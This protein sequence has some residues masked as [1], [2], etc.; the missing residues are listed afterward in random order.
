[1]YNPPIKYKGGTY[2]NDKK[3]IKEYKKIC[4]GIK[5]IEYTSWKQ[6][7]EEEISKIEDGRLLNLVKNY[8]IKIGR[9]NYLDKKDD[10]A[11]HNSNVIVIIISFLTT[12]ATVLISEVDNLGTAI[13][14]AMENV[15]EQL[16]LISN[17]NKSVGGLFEMI[18]QVSAC[19]F[20]ILLLC[21][22]F[23]SIFKT[24]MDIRDF[25]KVSYCEEM[26]KIINTEIEKR[27]QE[28]AMKEKKHKIK[29]KKQGK[30]KK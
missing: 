17:Y 23:M 11:S 8:E 2:I 12:W 21:F 3:R 26:I 28:V 27:K 7:V 16:A 14:G 19:M 10:T 5:G 6:S 24:L 9:R 30:K 29:D 20:L 25:E 4:R 15:E 1:M 22:G 13:Q 18:L